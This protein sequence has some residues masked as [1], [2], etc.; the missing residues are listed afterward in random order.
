MGCFEHLAKELM[1]SE[2]FGSSCQKM[3]EDSS[4]F[5]VGGG[6]VCKKCFS[7]FSCKIFAFH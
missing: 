5:A 3:S 1:G 7:S 4:F 2:V 6:R